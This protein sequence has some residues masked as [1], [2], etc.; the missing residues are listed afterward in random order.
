MVADIEAKQRFQK[1]FYESERHTIQ[2]DWLNFM[3]ELAVELGVKPNLFK[4]FVTDPELW[5]A[6]FFGPSV[7]YQYRLEGIPRKKILFQL[8]TY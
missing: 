4:Y 3:D 8:K 1:R 7:P 5:S 6:L 2:V